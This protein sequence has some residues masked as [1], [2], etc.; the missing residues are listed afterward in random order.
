MGASR[1]WARNSILIPSEGELPSPGLMPRIFI[2]KVPRAR[3]PASSF[4]PRDPL[5]SRIVTRK[6]WS[7]F[8][9]LPLFGSEE[10]ARVPCGGSPWR[11]ALLFL[12]AWCSHSLEEPCSLPLLLSCCW[13][14]FV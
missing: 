3:Q 4:D 2:H 14:V 8:F 7:Y 6:C 12:A 10:S 5:A 1:C 9:L 11:A 13:L